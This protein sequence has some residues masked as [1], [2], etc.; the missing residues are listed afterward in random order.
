MNETT[1][2]ALRV[3]GYEPQHGIQ[4]DELPVP[5]PGPGQ[6]R[7]RV[8]ACGISFVDLLLARGG[9]Q[10]RP[11]PPF[12]PGSEFCGVLDA[13]A[14]G[15]QTPLQ[16]GQLV[17][18]TR[19]GAWAQFICVD[20]GRVHRV[21]PQASVTEA[22]V[23][24]A[25]YATALYALLDRGHLRAGETVLVLGATG[26]VGHAAVQ[27]ARLL[28]AQVLA[29]ASTPA[30]REA[31]L[32]AGAHQVLD[33]ADP[34]WKAQ[35]RQHAGA[36]GVGLV[37]DTVGGDL[38]DTAFR[39]LGWEGRHLMVGFASGH[40]HALKSSL[41]IVKGASLI[42]VDY[43]QAGERAPVRATAIRDEVA[44]LYA[45]GRLRPRVHSVL[46]FAQFDEAA[47]LAQDRHT[48][49]RVVFTFPTQDTP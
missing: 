25:P 40:I 3:H 17:C 33:P 30:K 4:C 19:Q 41:A 43:R 7:V 5:E 29:V 12:I 45:Q 16:P 28:G 44:T 22:A 14:P 11:N 6:V 15:V 34:E 21:G 20:T 13:V 49:G 10:V 18:G 24:M 42:G 27:L 46:P 9:Y 39:T 35:V 8:A 36:A 1:M 48:L 23:L 2:K 32:Q 26:A 37:F 31:A 38:T 47:R